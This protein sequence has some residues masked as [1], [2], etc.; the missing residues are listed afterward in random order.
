[1]ASFDDLLKEAGDLNLNNKETKDYVQRRQIEVDREKERE[2]ERE[3]DA[4]RDRERERERE[5]ELHEAEENRLKR[6]HEQRMAQLGQNAGAGGSNGSPEAS[7]VKAPKVKLCPFKDTDKI[8]IFIA[9]FE[10]A[11]EY[12]QLDANAKRVQFANLFGGKALEVLHRLDEDNREYSDM[13][14]ALLAAYGMSVDELKEQFFSAKLGEDE[15]AIQFAARI[16]GYFNQWLKKDTAQESKEGIKDLVLRSVFIKSCP[17]ELVA[18]LKMDGAK[19]LDA[20]GKTADAYFEAKGKKKR[21]VK[22]AQSES[23]APNK[24]AQPNG[25]SAGAINRPHYPPRHS[26]ALPP[27][28]KPVNYGPRVNQGNYMQNRWNKGAAAIIEPQRRNSDVRQN[29]QVSYAPHR[30]QAQ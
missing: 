13:R 6:E 25:Q 7:G 16:K 19:T 20:V 9:R 22:S 23:P 28:Y 10:E 8:E 15:T 24:L 26:Q 11:A 5:R 29:A 30:E 1:M 27:R 14:K 21:P 3:K 4:A 2:R 18:K 12:M 17:E